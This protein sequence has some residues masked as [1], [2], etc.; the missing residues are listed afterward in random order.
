MKTPRWFMAGLLQVLVGCFGAGNTEA[1]ILTKEQ[2][3]RA[4]IEQNLGAR[5]PLNA[6]FRDETGRTLRLGS[7]FGERPVILVFAYYECPNLC[8][9]VLNG[10]LESA[11]NLRQAAG[12]DFESWW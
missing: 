12:R 1:Q 5:V 11:R 4:D 7:Y 10:L 8:H 6:T 9:L 2:I 3:A